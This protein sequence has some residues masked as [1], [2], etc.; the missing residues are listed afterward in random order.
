V[1]ALGELLRDG[2]IEPPDEKMRSYEKENSSRKKYQCL[3]SHLKFQDAIASD[4]DRS[5]SKLWGRNFFYNARKNRLKQ[6]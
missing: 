1:D 5:F 3:E 4:R 6:W 2:V